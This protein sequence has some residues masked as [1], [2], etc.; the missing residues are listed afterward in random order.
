MTKAPRFDAALIFWCTSEPSNLSLFQ[1][2]GDD[3]VLTSRFWVKIEIL[4]SQNPI[5]YAFVR[6][7]TLFSKIKQYFGQR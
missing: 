2:E 5:L 7:D 1:E 6:G 3:L 4:K